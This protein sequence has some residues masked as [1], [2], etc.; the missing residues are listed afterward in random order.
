VH[1][2]YYSDYVL[3][4]PI[5]YQDKLCTVAYHIETKQQFLFFLSSDFTAEFIPI[6]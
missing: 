3:G 4:R 2:C 1:R 5:K 6:P